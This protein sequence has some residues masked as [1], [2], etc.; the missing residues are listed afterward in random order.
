VKV[1]E[2][3]LPGV[4]IIEPDVYGDERGFFKETW[5]R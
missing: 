4:L 2:T 3:T 1:E 5:N